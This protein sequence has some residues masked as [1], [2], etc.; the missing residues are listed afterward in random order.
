MSLIDVRTNAFF[1]K[2]R[3]S[4]QLV[5]MVT[6]SGP[7]TARTGNAVYDRNRHAGQRYLRLPSSF[8]RL[9]ILFSCSLT[10][11]WYGSRRSSTRW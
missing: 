7:I 10:F 1:S 4:M 5:K 6:G 9:A 2:I 11:F 3:A 8:F